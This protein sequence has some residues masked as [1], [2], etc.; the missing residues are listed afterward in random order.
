MNSQW[1]Y[2]ILNVHVDNSWCTVRRVCFVTHKTELYYNF[3]YGVGTMPSMFWHCRLCSVLWAYGTAC[4]LWKV[5]WLV[6]RWS[7]LSAQK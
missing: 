1:K 3:W 6:G 5:G 7:P 2:N 4:G